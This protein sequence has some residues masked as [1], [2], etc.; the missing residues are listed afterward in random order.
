MASDLIGLMQGVFNSGVIDQIGKVVG[1][2]GAKTQAAVSGAVPSVLAG[3]LNGMGS[4]PGGAASI[5]GSLSKGGF[6]G[7]LNSLPSMLGGGSTSVDQL[8]GMGKQVLGSLLGDKQGAVSGA[9]AGS[10]GVSTSSAGSI[11]AMAAPAVLGMLG[12]Q[13]GSNATPSGLLSLLASSK[14]SIAK[15]APAGLLGAL[16]VKSFDQLAGNAAGMVEQAAAAGAR[17]WIPIAAIVAAVIIGYLAWQ[18]CG[19]QAQQASN[20]ATAAV[21]K[22]TS[23]ALPGGSTIN[24]LPDTFLYNLANYLGSTDPAP[25]TFIFDNLNF[26]SGGTT[27]TPASGPTVADLTR[28]LNAYPAVQVK[29]VGYTDTTGD[30]AA[31]VALSQARARAVADLLAKGGV[32]PSRMTT[33]GLGS[34]NPV[35]PNDSEEGRARNRR[36]ELV[37]SQK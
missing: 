31:N 5:L 37:V 20:A 18:N 15:F 35:G 26:E 3:V 17:K 7:V 8:V 14:D 29:L 1:E 13:L 6:D 28:V 19:Q 27:L 34:A 25:K 4:S 16:G 9:L 11:L 12:K 10:S 22:L 23:I 24:V 33:D 36:L 2:P 30:P 32:A 21:K